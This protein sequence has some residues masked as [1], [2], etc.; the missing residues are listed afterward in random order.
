MQRLLVANYPINQSIIAA[1]YASDY[2]RDLGTYKSIS[3]KGRDMHG[4]LKPTDDDDL[5]MDVEC[6]DGST[7]QA[8]CVAKRG[9]VKGVFEVKDGIKCTRRGDASGFHCGF[10]SCGKHTMSKIEIF[11]KSFIVKTKLQKLDNEFYWNLC[12]TAVYHS[13]HIRSIT[14]LPIARRLP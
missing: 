8:R 6:D 3:Y 10:N 2:K 9:L 4:R 1:C 12:I 5:Y 13:H 11:A 14:R 7:I